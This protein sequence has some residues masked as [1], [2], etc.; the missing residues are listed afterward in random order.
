MATIEQ[1]MRPQQDTMGPRMALPYQV[2]PASVAAKNPMVQNPMPFGG[3]VNSVNSPLT[4]SPQSRI[5]A[6]TNR[7]DVP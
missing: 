2:V 6:S 7:S 5:T 3:G 1:Q 4:V